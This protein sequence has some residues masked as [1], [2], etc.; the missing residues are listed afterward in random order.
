MVLCQPSASKVADLS[1]AEPVVE[2][3]IVTME[4][5]IG[6]A[7]PTLIIEKPTEQVSAVTEQV[8]VVIEDAIVLNVTEQV[9]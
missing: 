1:P 3:A 5:K 7:D 6:S 2:V 9:K 8:D 4:E